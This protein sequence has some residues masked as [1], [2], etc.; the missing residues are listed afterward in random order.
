VSELTQVGF[1]ADVGYPV[2]GPGTY[3]TPGY[4]GTLGHGFPTALGAKV[5]EPN[6]VV[7][8][9][10]GDGGFGWNL[11]ELATA[12]RHGIGLITI[13]FADGTF[14]N[15]QR[16]QREQ[17]DGRVY[18][19]DLANPDFLKLADAFGIAAERATTPGELVAAIR[20]GI[21]SGGPLLIE[22]PMPREVPS[23]WHLIHERPVEPNASPISHE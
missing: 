7:D 4:Q 13:V 12:K 6:R 20:R 22:V 18:A 21:A 5:R 15:V 8:S 9:I 3:I 17:F 19:T 23:P 14:G 11:Q 1:L 2:Y 10:N 16:M